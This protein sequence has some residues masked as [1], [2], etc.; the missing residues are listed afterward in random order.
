MTE[1]ERAEKI[2]MLELKADALEIQIKE[3]RDVRKSASTSAER[4]AIR[5]EAK[6]LKSELNAVMAEGR[7]VSGGI[8][9]GSGALI[10]ILII[11]LLL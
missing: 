9:I 5:M 11:L 3:L 4:K 8:Y 10:A 2:E 1:S 6:E 7:A